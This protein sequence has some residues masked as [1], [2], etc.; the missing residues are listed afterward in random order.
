MVLRAGLGRACEPESAAY[1]GIR[2]EL[3]QCLREFV[4][5]AGMKIADRLGFRVDHTVQAYVPGLISAVQAGVFAADDVRH[6]KYLAR[7]LW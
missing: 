7:H 3:E 5:V 4:C 1:V 6:G 2:G